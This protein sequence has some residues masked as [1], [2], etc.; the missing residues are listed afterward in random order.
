MTNS[1]LFCTHSLKVRLIK[2]DISYI[3]SYNTFISC[4]K[5]KEYCEAKM[6]QVIYILSI[7][8]LEYSAPH[9][10]LDGSYFIELE[11]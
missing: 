9:A 3:I 1:L 10:I 4:R 6:F 7:M 11:L 2:F 5:C 8:A